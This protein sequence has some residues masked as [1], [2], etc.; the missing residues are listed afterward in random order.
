MNRMWGDCSNKWWRRQNGMTHPFMYV[1]SEQ[2][3][4]CDESKSC[5][6]ELSRI[7]FWIF[8]TASDWI[9]WYGSHQYSKPTVLNGAHCV[10]KQNPEA[11]NGLGVFSYLVP[12]SAWDIMKIFGDWKTKVPRVVGQGL[13]FGCAEFQPVTCFLSYPFLCVKHPVTG[14][15]ESVFF[16][17]LHSLSAVPERPSKIYNSPVED[18]LSSSAVFTQ[19]PS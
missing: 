5:V 4:M 14:A 2:S 12:A 11:G 18:V 7:L 6:S 10:W 16:P 15:S 3:S 9:R 8:W 17:S 19:I 13:G 1:D